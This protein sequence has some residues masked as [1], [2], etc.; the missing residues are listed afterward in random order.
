MKPIEDCIVNDG[1]VASMRYFSRK[2]TVVRDKNRKI[3]TWMHY[4][5]ARSR[6]E[7]TVFGEAAPS[8]F[9]NYDDRLKYEDKWG[10]GLAIAKTKAS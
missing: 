6:Q 10:E 2:P 3:E 1:N 8:L 9:Y 7:T 4:S 5:D